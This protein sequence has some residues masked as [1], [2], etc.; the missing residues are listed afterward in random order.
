[1]LLSARK[2]YFKAINC[3]KVE[4]RDAYSPERN[5]WPAGRRRSCSCYTLDIKK[6]KREMEKY[7]CAI[8]L[9]AAYTHNSSPLPSLR[10]R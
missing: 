8:T 1:M 4:K 9:T 7:T 5:L 10:P 3:K 6:S 2:K